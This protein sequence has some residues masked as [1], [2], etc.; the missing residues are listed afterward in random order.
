MSIHNLIISLGWEWEIFA[1]WTHLDGGVPGS[2]RRLK[3][4]NCLALIDVPDHTLLTDVYDVSKILT[5]RNLNYEFTTGKQDAIAQLK[6]APLSILKTAE[7][8][9]LKQEYPLVEGLTDIY[10]AFKELIV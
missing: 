1:N 2:S 3:N 7:I 8:K 10:A 9:K 5:R 4:F 6:D